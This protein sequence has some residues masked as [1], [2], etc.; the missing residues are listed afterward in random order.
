MTTNLRRSL[1][2]V[3]GLVAVAAPALSA[4]GGTI[5]TDR[6]NVL[7][8]AGY[9]TATNGTH[10]VGTRIVASSNGQGVF[11]GTIALNASINPVTSTK[12]FAEQNALVGLSA[13]PG[14]SISI[15]PTGK[16][17]KVVGT[18]GIANLAST[19]KADGGVGGI[20]VTGS[21]QA[22]DIVPVKLTFADGGT[23]IVETP[24]VTDC[25]EYSGAGTST[26]SIP[27]AI[28]SPS[29]A[30]SPGIYDCAYPSIKPIG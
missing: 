23:A 29:T 20:P 30:A 22:G 12:S 11:I 26:Y 28:P 14:S 21:F 24:V 27:T 18:E 19:D 8:N 5:P 6:P 25:F 9:D 7:A 13:A 16:V 2:L 4:C 10:V 3:A 1:A 17:H 15:R